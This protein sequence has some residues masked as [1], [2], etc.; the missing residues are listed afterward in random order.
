MVLSSIYVHIIIELVR[1]SVVYVYDDIIILEKP[2]E[3]TRFGQIY[4]I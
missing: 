3:E 2:P 1:N 4:L